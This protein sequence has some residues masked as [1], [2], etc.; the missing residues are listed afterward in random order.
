MLTLGYNWFAM[1]FVIACKQLHP[2]VDVFVH[3]VPQIAAV[4]CYC[5]FDNSYIWHVIHAARHP[6]IVFAACE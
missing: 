3:A 5:L 1:S 4:D 6:E 2:I